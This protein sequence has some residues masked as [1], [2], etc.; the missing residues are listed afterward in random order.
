MIMK[1]YPSTLTYRIMAALCAIAFCLNNRGAGNFDFRCLDITNGL[2]DS[3]VSCICKGPGGFIWIGTA[4]G[5]S[6][7]DGFRFKNFYAKTGDKS[8]LSSNQVDDMQVDG[9]GNLWVLTNEGYSIYNSDTESFDSD[10]GAW[11]KRHGMK[12]K[13]GRVFADKRGNLWIAVNDLGCYYFNPKTDKAYLFKAGKHKDELPNGLITDITERGGS[14]VLSFNDGTLV[15]VD[16]ERHHVVWTNREIAKRNNRHEQYYRTFIDSNY[17]YW[18]SNHSNSCTWVYSSAQ[19]KWFDTPSEFLHS[20]GVKTKGRS[21]FIKDIKEDNRHNLWIATEHEGLFVVNISRKTS[22]NYV[23]DGDN[24]NSLP[25]N[26]LQSIY[27]D[28]AGAVWIGTYKNGVAYYSPQLSHYPT[29]RLGD[30]CT[31]TQDHA[32]NYWCGTNDKGIVCYNPATASTTTYAMSATHLGSNVVVSSLCASDGSLWFGTFGGGLARFSNGSF[33]VYRAST[34]GLLSDNI[35]SLTEDARG[36]IVAGT[37]GAGVLVLNPQTSAFTKYTTANSRLSSDYVSAVKVDRLGNYIVAHS[38]GV[39]IINPRKKTVTSL[40]KTSDGSTFS[41]NANNDL[42]VDSRGLIWNANMSGLDVYD[43]DTHRIYHIFSQPQNACGI[44]EDS[45]GNIWATLQAGVVKV[46]VSRKGEALNFFTNTFDET[47]GLQKRRFNYRSIYCDMSENI[48][49]GGQDGI[50]IIPSASATMPQANPRALF[51][52]VVLYDHQLSVGESYKNRV[53][54]QRAVNSSH[55]LLLDYDENAFTILL[56]SDMIAVPQKSHFLY[57]LK[58]FADDKWFMTVESQPSVTYTNLHPGTYI[59]QVKVVRRDGSVSNATSEMRIVV[60]PPFWLSWWAYLIYAA[61]LCLT[62]WFIWHRTI[63]RQMERMRIEQI[64]REAERKRK[65]DEMK[66]TFLTDISHEL[67]TPLSLVISPVEDMIKKEDDDRKRS[68][69]QLV[70]RNA[71]RLLDLVNQT[72][73]LRK[74]EANSMAIEAKADNIV[75]FVKNI[76]DDFSNLAQKDIHIS[77]NAEADKIV[78]PF[79]ADKMSKAINNL[80]SNAYKFTPE[81]GRV[82]VGIKTRQAYLQMPVRSNKVLEITV[83][84]TGCGISDENKKHVFD[85][86]YQVRNHNDRIFGGSGLGLSITKEYV[87]MHGGTISVA[88]NKHDGGTGTIFTIVLPITDEPVQPQTV[89][90][91]QREAEEAPLTKDNS[92]IGAKDKYELLV[93]DDSDDFLSFMTEILSEQYTV[94]TAVNGFDALK[95]IGQHKP[96][97]I[98]SDVMM[99]EMD[100]NALCKEVKDNPATKDIPFIMLTA[101]LSTDHK[102]EGFTSGADEYITKPFNLDLLNLRIKKLIDNQKGAV[103]QQTQVANAGRQTIT[104]NITE[105][106][107]TSVDQQLVDRATAFVEEHLSEPELSVE[108]MSEAMGMSRVNLYKKMLSITGTTP[109]EFIRNIRL[110]H[111][112]HLL[113]EGKLNVSEVAYRVGFNQPRIFSKYFKDFFG[114]LPSAVKSSNDEEKFAEKI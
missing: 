24:P 27:I 62:V 82:M 86:F 79:D 70:L 5:L 17:N 41:S 92:S 109:S 93:V 8:S 81:G 67:R 104:P 26:T 29:V 10:M 6:R 78:V 74:I 45:H 102:I 47:D 32:G 113:A 42:Y 105:E 108:M 91:E 57:R 112:R 36:N 22:D 9:D 99:P 106:E 88:D 11:M 3:H 35:W 89:E 34:S 52:G 31:I 56:S 13:P 44:T 48:V 72:L 54:L 114:M 1:N 16:G 58:G 64:Q 101:R 61:L 2:A 94:R 30:I 33:K 15:R 97:A 46:K 80:L 111:A 25:D 7:F 84:D 38:T 23:F 83:A 12:G 103:P 4:A 43:T 14:L 71:K 77:F 51:S 100:G 60:A 21:V 87:A 95:K 28:P 73:D 59:L 107:I 18:V 53:I 55:E 110:R 65:A 19:K 63:H 69:L 75:A 90:A 50:N 66:L 49:V 39:S 98:L 68:R 76:V 96:D 85:R 37:L 40:P 20:C